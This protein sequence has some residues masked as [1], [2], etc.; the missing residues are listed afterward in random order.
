[1]I[2]FILYKSGA[3]DLIQSTRCPKAKIALWKPWGELKKMG[4][5]KLTVWETQENARFGKRLC[6]E[7]HLK[8]GGQLKQEK[9]EIVNF[10]VWAISI[11]DL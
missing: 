6:M 9:G 3:S 8:K 10:D 5:L 4:A 2:F 7:Y 11:W 1:M